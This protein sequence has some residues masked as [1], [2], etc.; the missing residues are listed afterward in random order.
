MVVMMIKIFSLPKIGIVDNVSLLANFSEAIAANKQYEEE[1]KQWEAN[2][3]ILEDSIKTAVDV[4]SK[5]YEKASK[6]R[7]KELEQKLQE[8]NARYTQY[9]KNIERLY[10]TRREEIMGPVVTRVNDFVKQWAE[11]HGYDVIYGTGEGGVILSVTPSLNITSKVAKDL[12]ELYK[13]SGTKTSSSVNNHANS[14]L[15]EKAFNVSKN[16]SGNSTEAQTN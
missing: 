11:T 10:Y 8:C 3:A 13:V 6:E 5:E 9:T 7:K 16:K 2:I 4:L 14:A 15:N 12:N 1:K